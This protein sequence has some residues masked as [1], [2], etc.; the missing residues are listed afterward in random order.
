MSKLQFKFP[1]FSPS[2]KAYVDGVEKSLV[3]L[4]NRGANL[5]FRDTSDNSLY[6]VACP[7]GSY[8]N[9]I[10]FNVVWTDHVEPSPEPEPE[11]EPDPDPDPTPDPDPDPDPDTPTDDTTPD[12]D[13]TEGG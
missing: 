2:V 10:E 6:E 1:V 12:T 13:A 9:T 8:P 5:L 3:I 4:G 11:P 7:I